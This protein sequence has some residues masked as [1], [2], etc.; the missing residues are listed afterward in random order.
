MGGRDSEYYREYTSLCVDA[1][2]V[3]RTHAEPITWLMEIMSHRSNYP[4]FKY[5]PNAIRDFKRKM[6]LK[7]PDSDM[8]MA[9]EK[10]IEKSYKHTGTGLYDS[11]Q[12]ATN[13]IA[14]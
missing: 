7:T 11:F 8:K 2:R 9:V 5:N 13:G 10:L 4:A 3:A 6:L 1:L 14:K 12:L